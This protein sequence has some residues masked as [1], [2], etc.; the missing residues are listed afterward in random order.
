MAPDTNRTENRKLV[1]TELKDEDVIKFE[2]IKDYLVKKHYP[3]ETSD[4]LRWLVRE[5]YDQLKEK[6]AVLDK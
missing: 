1:K 6:K 5:T 2:A 3:N 4:I